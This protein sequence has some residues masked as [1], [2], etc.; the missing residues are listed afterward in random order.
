[1]YMVIFGAGASFD[2]DPA[3]PLDNG[4][5]EYRPPLGDELFMNLPTCNN[6]M[7]TFQQFDALVPWLRNPDDG[8]SVEAKLEKL[9]SDNVDPGRQRQVRSIVFYLQY[10]VWQFQRRWWDGHHGRT[11]YK[12]LIDQ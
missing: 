3:R 9:H 5:G 10:V 12:A 7:D 4:R 1:M 2:S 11:N 8:L 6:G